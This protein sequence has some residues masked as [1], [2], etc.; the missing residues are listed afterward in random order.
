MDDVEAVLAAGW[1]D[2]AAVMGLPHLSE[3]RGRSFTD[4]SPR[5]GESRTW[6]CSESTGLR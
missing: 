3:S 5:A 4:R 6:C 1:V 2:E